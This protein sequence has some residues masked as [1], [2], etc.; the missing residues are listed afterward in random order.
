M[1]GLGYILNWI[2]F[3]LGKNQSSAGFGDEVKADSEKRPGMNLRFRTAPQCFCG[4][5]GQSAFKTMFFT[6]EESYL[7]LTVE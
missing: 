7:P 5:T 6:D 2:R 4:D 3:C 1:S